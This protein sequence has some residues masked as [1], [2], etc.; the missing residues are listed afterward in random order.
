MKLLV[1]SSASAFGG[2]ELI[3]LKGLD[4][5]LADGHEL[6]LV[7][8]RINSRFVDALSPLTTRH[9]DRLRLH[10][11]DD[12]MRSLQIVR[13]WTN[14][15]RMLSLW[16]LVRAL[17]PD[18]VL[19]LQGDIEQGSE[20][21]LPARLAGVPV[22]SYVPM[23]MSG[24]DRGIRLARLRDALSR[25][26]Y[27]LAARFVVIAPY[28]RDQALARGAP[29]A[30][31]VSNCVD[32]DFLQAPVRR[33]RV[34]MELG[35]R[36]DERLAGYVGRIAYDQKGLDRLVELLR[37]HREHFKSN[38]LLIVGSGPDAARLQADLR[39]QGV[40]DCVLRRDWMDDRVGL[41]DAM[42]VFLCA[43]RFEG[44]PLS[45]LEALSRE[46]PVV[47]PPLPALAG[48][49]PLDFCDVPFSVDDFAARVRSHPVR[50]IADGVRPQ[51]STSGLARAE[52]AASFVRAVIS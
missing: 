37:G 40:E 31:V 39:A 11:R 6:D 1:Y 43:S 22:V 24:G 50:R 17:Q 23:V 30:I 36:E 15:P 13:T 47:A 2:H 48:K 44:V 16:R 21:F 14:V 42:D 28:F 49:L 34:R 27:A 25:P 45:V 26:I 41:F 35:V 4:A 46:V 19:A 9:G 38:R 12:Y 32:D 18:R 51:P 7:C 20:I 3:A 29:E 10:L 5:L 52:F 33:A 8:S